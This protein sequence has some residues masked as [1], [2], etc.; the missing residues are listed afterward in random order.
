ME[1]SKWISILSGLGCGAFASAFV[2]WLIELANWRIKIQRSNEILEV[3]LSAFK[4]A[5]QN[6]LISIIDTCAN[7][8]KSID[9]RIK[10]T[11]DQV[12]G[13]LNNADGQLSDWDRIY[14]NLGVELNR[15]EELTT[16]VYEPTPR[17]VKIHSIISNMKQNHNLYNDFTNKYIVSNN[18][19]GSLAYCFLESELSNQITYV[20]LLWNAGQPLQVELPETLKEMKMKNNNMGV[21]R[22]GF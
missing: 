13:L 1:E 7:Y 6:T 15:F 20:F 18:E 11:I 4:I 16:L 2:A 3:A 19:S 12:V 8:D 10:Y 21:N 22:D 9:V 17:N 5:V 14:H